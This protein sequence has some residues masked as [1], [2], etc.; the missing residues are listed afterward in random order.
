MNFK[1]V[2]G[3]QPSIPE[4]THFTKLKQQ[5]PAEVQFMVGRKLLLRKSQPYA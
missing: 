4:D 3:E 1:V 5:G 2:E